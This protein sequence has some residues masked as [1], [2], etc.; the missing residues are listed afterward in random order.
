MHPPVPVPALTNDPALVLLQPHGV[1]LDNH[2][3]KH[4]AVLMAG[5]NAFHEPGRTHGLFIDQVSELRHIDAGRARREGCKG[6]A[7]SHCC[8]EWEWDVIWAKSWIDRDDQ[9]SG[10]QQRDV[11]K[12]CAVCTG[13]TSVL[14]GLSFGRLVGSKGKARRQGEKARPR[15]LQGTGGTVRSTVLTV[16][17]E[18][19]RV[20][21]LL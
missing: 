8:R 5:A 2:L 13:S 10:A 7:L 21:G 1:W 18:Y 6:E 9:Q 3:D 11:M 15:L 19:S 17:Y 16:L 20:Y 14:S 4:D 12:G